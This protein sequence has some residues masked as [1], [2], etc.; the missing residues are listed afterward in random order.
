MF[1]PGVL[2]VRRK[3]GK[4]SI[5]PLTRPSQLRTNRC[6]CCRRMDAVMIQKLHNLGTVSRAI[7]FRVVMLSTS[8]RKGYG[9]ENLMRPCCTK[10][11]KNE[12]QY[13]SKCSAHP[14]ETLPGVSLA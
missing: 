4:F 12:S 7:R 13:K 8:T 6:D 14:S 3:G 2:I 9:T 5:A 1:E 11:E 10:G